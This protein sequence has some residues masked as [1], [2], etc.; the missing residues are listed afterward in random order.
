MP[1]PGSWGIRHQKIGQTLYLRKNKTVV[2][3]RNNPT[4]EAMRTADVN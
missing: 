1:I 2:K 3:M 4:Q